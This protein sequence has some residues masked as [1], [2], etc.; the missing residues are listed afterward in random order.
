MYVCVCVCVYPDWCVGTHRGQKKELDPQKLQLQ[1]TVNC[2]LWRLGT[3]LG[4][5]A[6]AVSRNFLSTI[7]FI[8]CMEVFCLHVCATCICLVP[9]GQKRMTDSLKLDLWAI[10]YKLP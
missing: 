10:G 3:E 2:L 8:L 7:I 4:S 1:V 6:K 9:R 5:L